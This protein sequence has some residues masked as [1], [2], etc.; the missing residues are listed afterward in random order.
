MSANRT[1]LRKLATAAGLIEPSPASFMLKQKELIEILSEK[2][3]QIEDLDDEAVEA[4]HAEIKAGGGGTAKKADSAKSEAS[5][6]P[7]KRGRGRPAKKPEPEPEEE[8][9]A[10]SEEEPAEETPEAE[11]A[12]PEEEEV[13]EE[14]AK[15]RRG[16]P[17]GKGRPAAPGDKKEPAKAETPKSTGG[18]D[19]KP[20]V[21][22]LDTVGPMIAK[23][24]DGVDKLR[25]DLDVM[26]AYL[27]WQYNS[28]V[29][30]D[31]A[32]QSLHDIEWTASDD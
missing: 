13:E 15:P 17:P 9:A 8:E 29:D 30:D 24:R 28:T 22:R 19:T 11:E 25:E 26:M 31:E 18:S 4:L 6:E 20:I 23:T 7:K 16:R 10:A 12:E 27:T 1:L 2:F 21:D 14:K 3:P 5:A 32:I